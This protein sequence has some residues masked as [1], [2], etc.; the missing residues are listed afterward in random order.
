MELNENQL[1]RLEQS[2]Q[3]LANQLSLSCLRRLTSRNNFELNESTTLCNAKHFTCETAVI[4]KRNLYL[5]YL[6]K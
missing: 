2:V 1:C 4:N 6:A 3:R 5:H